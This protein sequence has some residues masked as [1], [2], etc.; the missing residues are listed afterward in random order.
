MIKLLRFQT[1]FAILSLGV[2]LPI[3][4]TAAPAVD[5]QP[6]EKFVD[7]VA[8][9]SLL[10]CKQPTDKAFQT[11]AALGYRWVDLSCLNW[12]PHV[13]VPKLAE[14]FDREAARVEAALKANGLRAANLTFDAIETRPFEQYE[15]D[16][17]AVV[18]LAAR[19]K[20][21]L[22]NLMAPG[23]KANR[24]DM[25]V[26]LRKLQAIASEAGVILTLET[27]CNQV[28]EKPADALWL[29]QQAPGLA[30]TLDPSHYYAGPNQGANFDALYPYVQGTGFRAGGM[31]WQTI[32]MPWGE[33]PIDFA[34][35]VRQLQAH[36][37][38]GFYAVEYIE[39]FSQLEAVAEARKFIEWA[40]KL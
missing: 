18:K 19:L 8:C 33:G 1:C 7:R 16:F 28:T 35:V 30:L 22:I 37:Y 15:R 3:I 24:Q 6:S 26:K 38:K 5:G 32:Q 17:R 2:S 36:G 12:A 31:S 14:D 39:G 23:A 13:A 29:C 34:A 21:R 20:A 11:I 10:Q 25:V 9:S 40:R 4:S 27:H